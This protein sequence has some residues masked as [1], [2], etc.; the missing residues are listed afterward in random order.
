MIVT[1]VLETCP[2]VEL[3]FHVIPDIHFSV[4][5]A[6]YCII[7]HKLLGTKG[8]YKFCSVSIS[9]INNV[10]LA[11]LTATSETCLASCRSKS[12]C[13]NSRL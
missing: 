2:R 7:H 11:V 1:T 8:T 6:C 3:L 10:S 12:L 4:L 5:S 13:D 9:S